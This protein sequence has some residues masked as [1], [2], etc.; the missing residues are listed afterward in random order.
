MRK[1][2]AGF[3][4][5]RLVIVER[6]G[7][8]GRQRNFRVG[9]FADAQLRALNVGEDADRP[10]HA[11]LDAADARNQRAHHVMAGM[12][13]VDAEKV[14]TGQ[15]KLFDHGLFRRSGAEGG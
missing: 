10:A 5:R 15:E 13:H 7:L 3:V 8:A 9:E 11:L 6:E 2:N 14:R 1:E 12:A 4:A